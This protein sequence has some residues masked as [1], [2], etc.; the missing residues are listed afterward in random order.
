MMFRY[1][2]QFRRY[3]FSRFSILGF[4]SF[5]ALI[6][7]LV[8]FDKPGEVSLNS[9]SNERLNSITEL[10]VQELNICLPG[11]QEWV[12]T[13]EENMTTPSVTLIFVS[14]N[15]IRTNPFGRGLIEELN[16]VKEFD[17]QGLNMRLPGS[18]LCHN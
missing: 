6:L 18:R 7:F 10:D 4:I 3:Y 1:I 12:F 9:V 17:I 8:S 15:N 2:S 14:F 5:V 16:D 11:R 13:F